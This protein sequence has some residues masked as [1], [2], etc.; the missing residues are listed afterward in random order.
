MIYFINLLLISLMIFIRNFFKSGIFFYFAL[1]VMVV[2]PT[3]RS[4]NVGTDTYNYILMFEQVK[5]LKFI[6]IFESSI[7]KGY[8][9]F[10]YI[11]SRFFDSHQFFFL[12]FYLIVYS[13]FL[14]AFNSNSNYLYLSVLVFLCM[15]SYF[16]SFN[17][18]RQILAI[19]ICL[20][21]LKYVFDRQI[22]KFLLV[23]IFA[24]CF[25]ITALIFILV[26]FVYLFERYINY[27]LIFLGILFYLIFKFFISDILL[28]FNM[29]E[30]YSETGGNS[31]GI[32]TFLVYFIIFLYFCILSEKIENKKFLF[33]LN[34]M[35]IW[36]ML[37]F[38]F[39]LLKVELAGPMR[40]TLYYSWPLYFLF[41]LSL[42]A[43]KDK[44]Q[45]IL[46][47]FLYVLV[48]LGYLYIV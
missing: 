10:N 21:S 41:P 46:I 33:Y 28:F 17:I 13:N 14:R 9:I 8:L 15:G 4:E 24:S 47:Y 29:S 39:I 20:L 16:A 6:E 11:V 36:L 34:V 40:L 37:V 12:I 35:K 48:L 23:V 7:D 27:I 26:Y 3:F 43:Y 18:M 42:D 30:S 2:L 22:I 19:S 44:K 32:V 31:G 25:H 1:A 45:K 38:I 5:L